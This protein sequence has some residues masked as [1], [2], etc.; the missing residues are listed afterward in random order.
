MKDYE[1]F[2]GVKLINQQVDQLRQDKNRQSNLDNQNSKQGGM[3]TSGMRTSDYYSQSTGQTGSMAY[4]KNNRNNIGK[5]EGRDNNEN[6]VID[7]MM[8][9]AMESVA[10]VG[11]RP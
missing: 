2:L 5:R 9:S 1:S 8:G 7:D 3:S 11:S 4:S 10:S 6:D